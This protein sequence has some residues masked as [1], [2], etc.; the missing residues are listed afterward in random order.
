[1][2][3]KAER[4][5]EGFPSSHAVPKVRSAF[6]RQPIMARFPPYAGFL[7]SVIKLFYA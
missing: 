3:K 1:M 2:A 4:G 5:I 7:L 6:C